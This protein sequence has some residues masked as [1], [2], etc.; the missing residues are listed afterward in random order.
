MLKI[1]DIIYFLD[2]WYMTIESARIIEIKNDI[3]VVK[4]LD[5]FLLKLKH[6]QCFKT[7]DELLKKIRK[8]LRNEK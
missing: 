8:E 4:C 3:Y 5:G 6:E 1:N 2:N 7:K